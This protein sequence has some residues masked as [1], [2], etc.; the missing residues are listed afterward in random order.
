MASSRPVS[1]PVPNQTTN[2]DGQCLK[3]DIE[4]LKVELW[5]Q[6]TGTHVTCTHMHNIQA[7]TFTC[8][9][10]HTDRQCVTW[11]KGSMNRISEVRRETVI[12]KRDH[13]LV[14]M[15]LSW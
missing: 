8:S 2:K 13:K 4:A 5:L 1:D 10:M 7:H 14:A 15:H 9:H 6:H 11:N 3:K 12:A